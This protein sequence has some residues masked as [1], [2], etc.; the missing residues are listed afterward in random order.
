M[1]KTSPSRID[2]L[3]PRKCLD[4]PAVGIF[5][6]SRCPKCRAE[7]QDEYHEKAENDRNFKN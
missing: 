6:L 2:P 3:K 1:P 5:P 7:I 4:C